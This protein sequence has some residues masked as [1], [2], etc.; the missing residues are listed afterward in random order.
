MVDRQELKMIVLGATGVIG[1]AV[2]RALDPLGA[3]LRVAR[4]GGD[5]HVD[6]RSPADLK[7]FFERV[8]AFDHLIS[9]VGARLPMGAL[10]DLSRADMILAFEDKVQSQIQLVQAGLNHVRDHGSFTLS[11]GF[12]NREPVPGFSAI[13][14]A[15]GALEGFVKSAALDMERGVRINAVSPVF[16]L[17]SL[18]LAG[19][20]DTTPFVTMS[21]ADTALA[22]VA[23]V[24]GNYNGA[25][26]DPCAFVKV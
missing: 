4:S 13:A 8:G 15:N 7:A 25:N 24:E 26:L 20:T 16:V 10:R 12:L 22:Y 9:L 2:A 6:A 11:S 23:A 21:A 19:I 3:V 1:T 18:H 17:E 14:M 5:A